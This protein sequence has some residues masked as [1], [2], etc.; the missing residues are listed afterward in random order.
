MGS[1]HSVGVADGVTFDEII[2]NYLES[3]HHEAFY[4]VSPAFEV[5]A[6]RTLWV[7]L[8]YDSKTAN[9]GETIGTLASDLGVE[10]VVEGNLARFWI[11]L[12]I[13]TS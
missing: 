12:R 11:H 1:H 7:G 4:I 6:Y 9:H 5:I 10:P 2:A 8:Q 3:L 13:Q